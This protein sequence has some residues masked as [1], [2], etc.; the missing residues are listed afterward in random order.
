MWMRHETALAHA[1]AQATAAPAEDLRCA[2]LTRFTL[3]FLA[4]A[5]D[6]PEP[7][8]A[9]D[10]IFAMLEYGWNAGVG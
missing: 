2:E 9:L 3:E 4:L 5:N 10:G 7:A 8:A 6:R 1:S